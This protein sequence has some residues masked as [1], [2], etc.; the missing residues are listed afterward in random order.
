MKHLY[1]LLPVLGM[2]SFYA[3][4]TCAD[5]KRPARLSATQELLIAQAQFEAQEKLKTKAF[6]AVQE[7]APHYDIVMLSALCCTENNNYLRAREKL[8]VTEKADQK[9]RTDAYQDAAVASEAY[10]RRLYAVYAMQAKQ[11]PIKNN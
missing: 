7:I 6:A 2:V 10:T 11:Q 5:H 1:F 8:A 3:E 4:S 9:V